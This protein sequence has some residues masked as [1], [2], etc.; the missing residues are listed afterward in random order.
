MKH[1]F[2]QEPEFF[3][4]TTVSEKGQAVIPQEAR[5]AMKLH[6]GE[7]LLV[8]GRGT[9]AL[10]FVRIGEAEKLLEHLSKNVSLFKQAIQKHK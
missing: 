4:S 8:F 7:K 9:D 2:F 6:K 10:I 1:P 3:G 5:E